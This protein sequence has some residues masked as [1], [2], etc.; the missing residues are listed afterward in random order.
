VLTNRS[1]HTLYNIEAL[2]RVNG[3]LKRRLV[4]EKLDGNAQFII[5][6]AGQNIYTS[7]FNDLT[8]TG[9]RIRI[10]EVLRLPG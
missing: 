3:E 10:N 9:R 1:Q 5:E 2:V 7:P 6:L 4:T 8:I